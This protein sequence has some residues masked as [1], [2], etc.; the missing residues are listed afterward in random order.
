MGNQEGQDVSGT[1]LS[2]SSFQVP[3]VETID[4]PKSLAGVRDQTDILSLVTWDR[5]SADKTP[6]LLII[7][8]CVAC[9]KVFHAAV[10]CLQSIS[11]NKKTGCL[12]NSHLI[13]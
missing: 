1:C 6:P 12:K 3:K 13:G 11:D 8:L 2:S 7:I 10:Y 4:T 9:V 5:M